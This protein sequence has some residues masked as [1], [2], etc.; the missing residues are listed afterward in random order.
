LSDARAPVASTHTPHAQADND[1]SPPTGTGGMFGSQT[2]VVRGGHHGSA[3]VLPS[4]PEK[5]WP[6]DVLA[7]KTA[8]AA[9]GK[10]LLSHQKRG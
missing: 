5:R 4:D 9:G 8:A 1:G 7:N 2:S 10:G 3:P 6:F